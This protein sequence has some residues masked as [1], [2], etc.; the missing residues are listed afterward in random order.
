MP[1]GGCFYFGTCTLSLFNGILHFRTSGLAK[2]SLLNPISCNRIILPD[3]P[4]ISPPHRVLSCDY[5]DALAVR[6]RRDAKT[7]PNVPTIII[8]KVDDESES[9]SSSNDSV[10]P[11]KSKIFSQIQQVKFVKSGEEVSR[12]GD[13][14][15]KEEAEKCIEE[16]KSIV[17]DF[18]KC[19]LQYTLPKAEHD[20]LKVSNDTEN[21][22]TETI[23]LFNMD[24]SSAGSDSDD[25]D[26]LIYAY[27]PL[28]SSLSDLPTVHHHTN[29]IRVGTKNLHKSLETIPSD[30]DV[31]PV[32][33]YKSLNLNEGWSVK[34]LKKNFEYQEQNGSAVR[35]P[36]K[37]CQHNKLKIFDKCE[38]KSVSEVCK[39]NHNGGVS[40]ECSSPTRIGIQRLGK[41]AALTSHFSSLGSAGLI[42][43]HQSC[44]NM[45]MNDAPIMCKN[46]QL[47]MDA[48]TQTAGHLS[49]NRSLT[50]AQVQTSEV[51]RLY[52][53][54][55]NLPIPKKKLNLANI[56]DQSDYSYDYS[57][58][59]MLGLKKI[60]FSLD[61][62]LGF[63]AER[64]IASNKS[65]SCP[66][67]KGEC[68]REKEKQRKFPDDY[69]QRRKPKSNDD[70][71]RSKWSS[72]EYLNSSVPIIDKTM[73]PVGGTSSSHCS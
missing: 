25:S 44:T 62:L 68:F 27:Q 24:S 20:S 41:V 40:K 6:S 50:E 61:N 3:D 38:P 15:S 34:E 55:S 30:F 54:S 66:V 37:L 29:L 42:K 73:T 22:K 12:T 14:L 2:G 67:I 26:S 63:P 19:S 59:Y 65:R 47:K 7:I 35:S 48:E 43:F 52:R 57:L 23:P 18:E 5:E 53:G 13:L 58:I 56:R 70:Q 39:R 31:K 51:D 1:S 45:K 64:L 36:R 60:G 8:D 17:A 33:K 49:F 72:Q 21:S 9:S 11:N 16:L 10:D 28:T 69:I 4:F 71:S 32:K 46:R